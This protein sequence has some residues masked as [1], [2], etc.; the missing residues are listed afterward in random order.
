MERWLIVRKDGTLLMHVENDGPRFLAYGAEAQ[1]FPI[2]VEE[3][4][5][6]YPSIYA[7]YAAGHDAP[8]PGG[9]VVW[10]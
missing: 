5:S 10:E 3:L 6:R 4:Q 7:V 1:E 8:D 2:T 9:R